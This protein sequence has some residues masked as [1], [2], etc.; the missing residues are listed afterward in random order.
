MAKTV[1]CKVMISSQYRDETVNI[2]VQ[3]VFDTTLNNKG[4][5]NKRK[6]E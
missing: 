2:A 3:G 4:L 5:D 1:N 6:T